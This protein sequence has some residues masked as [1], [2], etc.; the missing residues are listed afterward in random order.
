M[1]LL[2]L[3]NVTMVDPIRA[4]LTIGTDEI[5]PDN[6]DMPES[7]KA[8]AISFTK[9]SDGR[10]FTQARR[11]RSE[12]GYEGPLIAV[13]HIIPDQADFLRRCGFSHAEIDQDKLAQ[14]QFSI[15]IIRT[16]FQ[17]V[18]QSHHSRINPS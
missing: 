11:L 13:G 7:G 18:L 4:V 14:W 3:D 8:I 12:F 10:G 6:L 5:L 15:G 2:D 9:F 17:T 1:P 16:R